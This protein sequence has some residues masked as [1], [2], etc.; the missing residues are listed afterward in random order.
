MLNLT[1]NNKKKKFNCDLLSANEH[2][3]L[4]TNMLYL[5]KFYTKPQETNHHKIVYFLCAFVSHTNKKVLQW[6]IFWVIVQPIAANAVTA[7]L[8]GASPHA[9]VHGW[10]FKNLFRH[11]SL[12]YR[13][14]FPKSASSRALLTKPLRMQVASFNWRKACSLSSTSA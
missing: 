4:S 5:L 9:L 13:L 12:S 14:R 2:K 11:F 10:F 7:K 8:I 1:Q 3:K 6:C